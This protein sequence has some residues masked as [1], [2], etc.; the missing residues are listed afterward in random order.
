[1]IQSGS[2]IGP[3][4]AIDLGGPPAPNVIVDP[5]LAYSLYAE[6]E[7]DKRIRLGEIASSFG[8]EFIA[9][10][11]QGIADNIYFPQPGATPKFK[12]MPVQ[13]GWLVVAIRPQKLAEAAAQLNCEPSP[14]LRANAGQQ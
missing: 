13:T 2:I 9:K 6:A 5:H 3:A 10:R 12:G 7:G 1:M 8:A 4:V 14:E 11:L